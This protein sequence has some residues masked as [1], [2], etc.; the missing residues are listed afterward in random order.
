MGR[1]LAV[2]SLTTVKLSSLP[3]QKQSIRL[4][5][6]V[7]LDARRVAS[8]NIGLSAVLLIRP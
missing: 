3:E 7:L 2:F 6:V 8:Y 4:S 1:T 5:G